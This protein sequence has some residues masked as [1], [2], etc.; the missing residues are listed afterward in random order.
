MKQTCLFVFYNTSIYYML[1]FRIFVTI[2]P[3][4]F[5][6]HIFELIIFHRVA[7]KRV[8]LFDMKYVAYIKLRSLTWIYAT[9]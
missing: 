9:G 5:F 1:G 7:C 4:F 6:I 3:V 2:I 8:V